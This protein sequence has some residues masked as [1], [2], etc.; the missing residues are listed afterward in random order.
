MSEGAMRP[1][2]RSVDLMVRDEIETTI[3]SDV[4]IVVEVR[5]QGTDI[6][7]EIGVAVFISKK[8]K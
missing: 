4:D 5:F 3:L 2:P 7:F 1:L 6:P 8:S